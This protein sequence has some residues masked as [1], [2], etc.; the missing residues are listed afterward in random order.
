MSLGWLPYAEK[1]KELNQIRCLRARPVSGG[2]QVPIPE[3]QVIPGGIVGSVSGSIQ[4]CAEAI[5]PVL[6]PTED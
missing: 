1:S 3:P 2:I 6:L 4:V 5:S